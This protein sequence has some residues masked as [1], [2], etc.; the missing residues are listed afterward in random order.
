VLTQ[1]DDHSTDRAIVT[2]RRLWWSLCSLAL[3]VVAT[4]GAVVFEAM[5]GRFSGV[6]MQV[7]IDECTPRKLRMTTFRIRGSSVELRYEGVAE[8][9]IVVRPPEATAPLVASLR[10]RFWEKAFGPSTAFATFDK[11]ASVGDVFQLRSDETVTLM[12][13]ESGFSTERWAMT[14]CVEP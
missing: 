10:S 14:A 6:V 8:N 12:S 5:T 2:R 7:R 1:I 3:F 4:T 11:P 9:T 13:W